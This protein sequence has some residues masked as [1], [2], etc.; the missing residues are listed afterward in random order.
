MLIVDWVHSLLESS[1]QGSKV[2]FI[3]IRSIWKQLKNYKNLT[4]QLSI[5]NTISSGIEP[6]HRDKF[7]KIYK[8]IFHTA[9]IPYGKHSAPRKFITAKTLDGKNSLRQKFR[10]AKNPYGE[11]SYGDKSYGE[12]S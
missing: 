5:K 6:K 1:L 2:I 3:E 9:K 11:N 7:V 12:K 4:T 8:P 10:S